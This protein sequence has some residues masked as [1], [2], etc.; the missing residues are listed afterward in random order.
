[1]PRDRQR[2]RPASEQIGTGGLSRQYEPS[3]R[4]SYKRNPDYWNKQSPTSIAEIPLITQ[5]ANG[6]AQFKAGNVSYNV[7][8]TTSRKRDACDRDVPH[9]ATANP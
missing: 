5:Y 7:L 9:A 4:L 6:L 3:V 1:M 2:L 8:P